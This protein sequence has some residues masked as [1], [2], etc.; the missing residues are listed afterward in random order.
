V[1]F[2]IA[3]NQQYR[4]QEGNLRETTT[5]VPIV[6]QGPQAEY[7]TQSLKKGY[8][9]AVDGRLRIDTFQTEEGERRKVVEVIAQQVEFLGRQPPE[10]GEKPPEEPPPSQTPSTRVMY[11]WN[12]KTSVKAEAIWNDLDEKVEYRCTKCG[13]LIGSHR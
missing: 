3:V 12:C 11:C 7:C 4:D 8:A 6:V 5:L 1:S 10:E 2:C 13:Y 9:V